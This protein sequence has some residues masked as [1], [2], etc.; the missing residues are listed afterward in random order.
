MYSVIIYVILSELCTT[1]SKINLFI[2]SYLVLHLYCQKPLLSITD[3]F[4]NI[5]SQ[6]CLNFFA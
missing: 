2:C 4:L 6:T 1:Y 3:N 5:Y